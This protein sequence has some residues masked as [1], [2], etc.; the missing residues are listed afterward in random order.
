[1][2]RRC[3]AQGCRNKGAGRDTP[4]HM[5]PR[6]EKLRQLWIRAVQPSRPGWTPGKH[7][8]VCS[9]HFCDDD[10]RTSPTLL[11]SLGMSLRWQRLKPDAVPSLLPRNVE[12]MS[13]AFKERRRKEIIDQ[14]LKEQSTNGEACCT[15]AVHIGKLQRDAGKTPITSI[16]G[17]VF[18]ECGEEACKNSREKV[19]CASYQ[20]MC[21]EVLCR[22]FSPEAHAANAREIAPKPLQTDATVQAS[23]IRRHQGTQVNIRGKSCGVQTSCFRL[24]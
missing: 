15:G 2:P 22:K 16:T 18:C 7:D 1:M 6:D 13:D 12:R 10:Y 19:E 11:K 3:F 24:P 20:R 17:A 9:E 8:F 21:P 23:L 14:I 5:F 4:S